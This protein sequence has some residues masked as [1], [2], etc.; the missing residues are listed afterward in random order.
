MREHFIIKKAKNNVLKELN[1]IGF[2]DS[3]A[4]KASDKYEN[5]TLKIFN[6]RAP[7]ANILKQLSL[8]LGFDCAVHKDTITCKCEKT[9]CLISATKSQFVKLI[10]KLKVQPFKLKALSDDLSD[11]INNSQEN[12]TLRNTIFEAK[13]TYIVGILN[14]TPD[15]FSDGGNYIEVESAVSR[16]IEMIEEGADILDIGGESTRP[17]S[18]PISTEEEI[19][20]VIPV[21]KEIRKYNKT[22]P[23]SVDTRN[24]LTAKTAIESGADIINDVSGLDYDNK[25]FEYVCSEN[26]PVI[27]MHS[28]KVP[29]ETPSED[30]QHDVIEEI[31]KSL[32]DKIE[33]LT[34]KGLNKNKIIIDPGIGFGKSISENFEI[35]KR[36]EEFSTLNCKILVGLSRKSFIKNSFNLTKEELDEATLVY[37]NYLLSKGVNFIRVHDVKNH[38]K[39]MEFIRK[40]L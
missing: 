16:A 38:K 5:I 22:I 29:A 19:S 24:Y 20:R 1:E 40:V 36:I 17:N 10:K 21:I 12:L 27:I 3:Y 7:E 11:V 31:Y 6:L 14:V 15:S 2:D 8:S 13:K 23:I 26:I 9:D 32:H 39:Q 33:V 37:D 18:Q 34:N 35:V 25:L 4:I 30:K 28:D